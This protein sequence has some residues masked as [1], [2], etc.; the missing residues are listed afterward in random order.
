MEFEYTYLDADKNPFSS[1]NYPFYKKWS[2]YSAKD[3]GRA[4]FSDG[5][6]KSMG[7]PMV[8]D[9]IRIFTNSNFGF[10]NEPMYYKNY[11][12]K[13]FIYTLDDY[14]DLKDKYYKAE[15]DFDQMCVFF[16]KQENEII[17]KI[18]LGDSL[19]K[20]SRFE[21][22][23][24]TA[25]F[26]IIKSLKEI[27]DIELSTKK[28]I[29]FLSKE[30]PLFHTDLMQDYRNIELKEVY[31]LDEKEQIISLLH[32]DILD[33][34]ISNVL[35]GEK[36]K[37]RVTGN[38]IQFNTLV[39]IKLI[40]KS[41]N[42]NQKFE[43]IEKMVWEAKFDD[44]IAETPYFQ[45]PLIW[46]DESI[47]KYNYREDKKKPLE[48][49]PK[50]YKTTFDKKLPEFSIEVNFGKVQKL[51]NKEEHT[52][53][54]T[55]Y[56]RNYEEL[57]GLF[58]KD[59]NSGEKTITDNYENEFIS[60][61]K[62]IEKIVK[63]FVSYVETFPQEVY[64]YKPYLAKGFNDEQKK[65]LELREI[66]K[67][68][69]NDAAELWKKAV[70]PFQEYGSKKNYD[71]R[72]LY[73]ARLKMQS[74]L[75]RLPI[76]KN[77]I[78]FNTSQVKKDA[79]LD[80]IIT[81]FEE[82]SRNY[83][84]I[85]FGFSTSKKILITGFDPFFLNSI[86]HNKREIK[87]VSNIKQSNPSGCVALWL[88]GNDREMKYCKVQTMIVPVRYA[89]FDNSDNPE[90]GIGEGIIEKYIKPW[91]NKVNMIITISQYLPD[92][93]VIDMFATLRRGGTIDNMNFLREEVS[94]SI[95]TK[96]EWIQTT[97]K[98]KFVYDEKVKLNWKYNGIEN[99]TEKYPKNDEILFEGSG[100]DYLSN[101]I[102]YRVAKLRLENKPT[103]P[104]GH[105]HIAMLQKVGKDFDETETKKLINLVIESIN[106]ASKNL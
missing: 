23:D 24:Q 96:T 84:G 87:G 60:L 86:E 2:R 63:G 105:F 31:F 5:N 76:F 9:H 79:K 73:W 22:A 40:A 61:N 72:P 83:T 100:G 13:L 70:E 26:T 78:D 106:K 18:K 7:M 91:I 75:K 53:I 37:I 93:T 56:R 62:E 49:E 21:N 50:A 17:T 32:D 54:P 74:Q 45:I 85:N 42:E 94:K 65:D 6:V 12:I 27:Q 69:E 64:K 51:V 10:S 66:T 38:Q 71:D 28:I 89:D 48:E 77:D 16:C 101:E 29:E 92:K 43:G 39:T 33:L 44:N 58:K 55:S 14:A 20:N 52:L 41:E 34:P 11:E 30:K 104:T 90:K 19:Q 25:N 99:P 1:K 59:N 3:L 35:F 97:L 47:E 4:F 82:K 46:F 67:R 57:I 15:L 102:F 98:E 103:L 88:A 81:I 80:K 36:V 68:V 8:Y 95:E